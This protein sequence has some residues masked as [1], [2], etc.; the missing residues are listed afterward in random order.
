MT[1]RP[2]APFTSSPWLGPASENRYAPQD[3]TLGFELTKRALGC[4]A[5]EG[6]EYGVSL[7]VVSQRPWDNGRLAYSAAFLSGSGSGSP[8]VTNS[9]AA[10]GWM[11]TVASKTC[12]VAPAL[13]ATAMP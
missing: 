3:A 5:K 13:I 7:R 1:R 9:S 6:R 11:P 8:M 12:L 4:I 10:V 2:S